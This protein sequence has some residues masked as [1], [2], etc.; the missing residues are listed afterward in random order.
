MGGNFLRGGCMVVVLGAMACRAGADDDAASRMT[1]ATSEDACARYA[2]VAEICGEPASAGQ[3]TASEA[4]ERARR[5]ILAESQ[6]TPESRA[7]IA[8]R[9]EQLTAA[10]TSDAACARAVG[11]RRAR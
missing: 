7:L 11:A 2:R 5:A 4:S 10:L 3:S 8:A 1:S 6:G 9:C